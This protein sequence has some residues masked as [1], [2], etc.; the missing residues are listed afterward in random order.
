MKKALLYAVPPVS[1]RNRQ[2]NVSI[3][4]RCTQNHRSVNSEHIPFLDIDDVVEP[5]VIQ[6]LERLLVPCLFIFGPKHWVRF[7]K[8]LVRWHRELGYPH[9]TTVVLVSTRAAQVVASHARMMRKRRAATSSPRCHNPHSLNLKTFTGK[10]F[11]FKLRDLP[12]CV[13]RKRLPIM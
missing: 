3:F 13:R 2:D 12:S 11:R 4:I 8:N 10:A 5:E 9:V 6:V 7:M 1:L